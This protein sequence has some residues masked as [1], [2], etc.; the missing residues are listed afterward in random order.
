ML[1]AVI[2]SP[3]NSSAT[4]TPPTE[5][6]EKSA[7]TLGLTGSLEKQFVVN[8]IYWLWAGGTPS[9]INDTDSPA[10]ARPTPPSSVTYEP[11]IWWFASWT[12]NGPTSPT[13]QTPGIGCV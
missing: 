10:V 9:L 13:S 6:N 3:T 5:T 7:F 1:I 11:E 8:N 12:T 2:P 4:A